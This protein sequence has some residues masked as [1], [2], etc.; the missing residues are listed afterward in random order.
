MSPRIR[1]LAII[2]ACA[3]PLGATAA[4]ITLRDEA[5][6]VPGGLVRLRDVAAVTGAG[7]EALAD[8]P[9]MPSPAP[10]TS[11]LLSAGA[12]RDML[13][14]QGHSI[15]RHRYRGAYN[16]RVS[17]PTD[18]V[19]ADI[20]S[21]GWRAAPASDPRGTAFRVL[22]TITREAPGPRPRSITPAQVKAAHERVAAIVQ[23]ALDQRRAPGSPRLA[24][25]GVE[26]SAVG[27]RR[28]AEAADEPI[29]AV[30]NENPP[31]TPGKLRAPLLIGG[32]ADDS[33]AA[34]I[35]LVE[36]PPRVVAATPLKP[37]ALLTTSSLRIELVPVEEVGRPRSGGY[38]TLEEAVG[39]EATRSLRA[40]EP[41]SDENTA[42]PLMVRRGEEVVV[43][44]GGGGVSVSLRVIATQEG[45]V[46]DLVTVETADRSDRFSARV[47]G[48]RKLAV[49]AG[50]PG[51]NDTAL[52]GRP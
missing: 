30:L 13:A 38:T 33:L 10:G 16:V 29:V 42:T 39:R 40:G 37:G 31:L 48:P 46:G 5:A 43:V 4:E 8:A 51:L 52:G 24:V 18:S 14:A 15:G 47:V 21:E 11:Q 28:V 9:L 6:S 1:T 41:L 36:Q 20:D 2:A 25:R 12:V 45:R 44:S 17:T 26:L 19:A 23:E 22:P 3:A 27:Q 34:L 50:A 35:D 7:A 32:S 49:L